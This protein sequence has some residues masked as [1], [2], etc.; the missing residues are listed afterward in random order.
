M[1]NH[2]TNSD[3]LDNSGKKGNGSTVK[4]DIKH[5]EKGSHTKIRLTR[6]CIEEVTD[7]EERRNNKPEERSFIDGVK[8]PEV[9]VAC[10]GSSQ[11][12]DTEPVKSASHQPEQDVLSDSLNGLPDKEE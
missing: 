12:E 1:S 9:Q 3:S 11:P 4:T 10:K 7:K 6:V 5:K 2:M 8:L